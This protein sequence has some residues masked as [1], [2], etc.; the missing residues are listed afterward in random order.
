MRAQFKIISEC[1]FQFMRYT[2]WRHPFE[3]DSDISKALGEDR[4]IVLK[5]LQTA[6]EDKSV[7]GTLHEI[8][9]FDIDADRADYLL[10]DGHA[11]GAEFGRFDL[12][13]NSGWN[14]RSKGKA[15]HLNLR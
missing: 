5:I 8:V 12:C 10:R 3:S 9:A 15:S 6:P 7:C 11:S 13:I 2:D 14:S 1:I 4:E